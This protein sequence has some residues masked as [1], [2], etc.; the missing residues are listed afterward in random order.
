[1]ADWAAWVVTVVSLAVAVVLLGCIV[2]ST[3][4]GRGDDEEA[5]S[6]PGR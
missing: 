4:R 1:V 3:V 6:Q 5:V 2:L